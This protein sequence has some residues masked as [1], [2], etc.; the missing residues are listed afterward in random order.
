MDFTTDYQY[1]T[2]P[3]PVQVYILYSE[4]LRGYLYNK[5]LSAP[6]FVLYVIFS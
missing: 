6:I 4:M 2:R 1:W 3:S 5:A